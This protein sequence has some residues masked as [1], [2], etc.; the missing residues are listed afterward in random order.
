MEMD[1]L[2]GAGS[3]IEGRELTKI[4]KPEHLWAKPTI[5]VDNV[6]ITIHEGEILALVGESGSGKSTLGRLLLCL[7]PPTKGT[8]LYKDQDLSQLKK[9]DLRSLRKIFQ[10]VQQHPDDALNGKW[11]IADSILEPFRVHP[12]CISDKGLEDDLKRLIDLVGLDA[13]Q[14][15][16]YPHQL[17]GG[18]LQRAVFARAIA[19]KPRF[20]VCDEP[21]SMLDVSIQASLIRLLKQLHEELNFT[22]LY[23]TH[24][25]KL[26]RVIS[27][28]V[29]VMFGGH[30]IEEGIGILD[31]PLHPYTR[32]LIQAEDDS[33]P[34]IPEEIIPDEDI[35]VYYPFCSYRNEM[36]RE[37]QVL[38][39][40]KNRRIAC[41]LAGTLE[42][43]ANKSSSE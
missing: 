31:D 24:D 33:L 23:I 9:K 35:C 39:P 30:I 21:T 32:R 28:R 20:I 22:C 8:L 29:A 40:Y 7:I 14:V 1:L 6:D 16:R 15:K 43:A 17:S 34:D 26:A 36:C 3:M 18:E 5:A 4:Y 13:E 42:G 12:D 11:T 10:I 2:S 25:L 19:L 27:D 38:R 41:A 37:K